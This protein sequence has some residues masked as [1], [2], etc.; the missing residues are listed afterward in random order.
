MA[1]EADSSDGIACP[2]CEGLGTITSFL[3]LCL[4]CKGVGRIPDPNKPAAEPAP[5][6]E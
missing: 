6:D 4:D 5:N 3:M 1:K 2:E